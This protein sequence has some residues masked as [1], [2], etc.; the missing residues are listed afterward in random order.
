M[1]MQRRDGKRVGRCT[2]ECRRVQEAAIQSVALKARHACEGVAKSKRRNE[3][4]TEAR[5]EKMTKVTAGRRRDAQIP[6][7]SECGPKNEW[8]KRSKRQCA[9]MRD[10]AATV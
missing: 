10:G 1:R 7:K 4:G 6:Q 9:L 5:R 8:P 3:A 2:N